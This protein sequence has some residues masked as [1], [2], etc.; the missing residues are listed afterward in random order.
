MGLT[1][2]IRK[3]IK[4]INPASRI[5]LVVCAIFAYAIIRFSDKYVDKLSVF[6]TASIA[7]AVGLVQYFSYQD[8][9]MNNRE[10]EIMKCCGAIEYLIH[11]SNAYFSKGNIHESAIE[12]QHDNG[13]TFYLEWEFYF[14]YPIKTSVLIVIPKL[15][16]DD[17][18]FN[19]SKKFQSIEYYTVADIKYLRHYEWHEHHRGDVNI[20]EKRKIIGISDYSDYEW[21]M[22]MTAV[23]HIMNDLVSKQKV[24]K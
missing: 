20:D 14:E 23:R 11:H 1:K 18:E 24:Q 4:Y 6:A 5:F 16:K 21:D 17:S 9:K 19:K 12:L 13:D 2:Y 15:F 8:S 7:A 10:L 22:M 3:R